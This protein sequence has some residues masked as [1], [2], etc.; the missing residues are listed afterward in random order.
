MFVLVERTKTYCTGRTCSGLIIRDCSLLSKNKS[1]QRIPSEQRRYLGES[2]FEDHE[3]NGLRNI[4]DRQY[5]GVA[6]HWI[7]ALGSSGLGQIK[8]LAVEAEMGDCRSGDM[9]SVFPM[10]NNLQDLIKDIFGR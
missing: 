1:G 9:F 6:S 4:L 8:H 2:D 7:A 10:T 3:I 5:D